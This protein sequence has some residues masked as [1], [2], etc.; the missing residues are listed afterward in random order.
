VLSTESGT[1]PDDWDVRTDNLTIN[2]ADAQSESNDSQSYDRMH[3]RLVYC[4]KKPPI[5][6]RMN[7]DTEALNAASWLAVDNRRLKNC[8]FLAK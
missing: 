5:G 7:I 4:G 2:I 6:P 8:C 1:R 3:F